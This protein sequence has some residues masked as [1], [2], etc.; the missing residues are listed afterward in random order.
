MCKLLKRAKLCNDLGCLVNC[1]TTSK[2]WLRLIS[3]Y[4]HWWRNLLQSGGAQVHVKK[5]VENFCNLN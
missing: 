5:V 3:C 2:D 1:I 4:E